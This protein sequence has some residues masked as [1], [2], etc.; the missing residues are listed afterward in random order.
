MTVKI[1]V[2][3]E[4][5]AKG[6]PRF[7]TV[8]KRDGDVFVSTYT[9]KKTAAYED[10]IRWSYKAQSGAT[11]FHKDRE[12]SLTANAYFAIPKS[13]SKKKRRLMEDG[14]IR[15]VKR[16]DADNI[17]KAIAD[18]L[19]GIAYHDDAQIVSARIEK[20]WSDNPRVEIEIGEVN[21]REPHEKG[22]NKP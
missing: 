5:V 15:P 3:G 13:A 20:F 16:P 4:P 12:L 2:Q 6:R 21:E 22:E 19:N 1:T 11:F 14:H 10:L 7:S 18:A 17:L 8:R 9:P